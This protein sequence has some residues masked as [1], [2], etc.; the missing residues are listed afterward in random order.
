MPSPFTPLVQPVPLVHISTVGHHV[1]FALIIIGVEVVSPET[2]LSVHHPVTLVTQQM[3]T[4][5]NAILEVTSLRME[6]VFHVL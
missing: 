5:L 4:V 1:C 6:N 3:A 2:A